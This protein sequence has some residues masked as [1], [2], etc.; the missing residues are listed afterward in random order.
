MC[1]EEMGRK[2]PKGKEKFPKSLVNQGKK[3]R[4]KKPNKQGR[5]IKNTLKMLFCFSFF[6]AEEFEVLHFLGVLQEQQS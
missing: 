1:S 3:K 6:A 5:N 2:D 4:Q